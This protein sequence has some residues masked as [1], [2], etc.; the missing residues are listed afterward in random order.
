MHIRVKI[1]ISTLY[2]S[3]DDIENWAAFIIG[4]IGGLTYL[5]VGRIV[6]WLKIDDP[7]DAIPIHFG[8]GFMGAMMPGWFVRSSG[9]F[10]SHG[11]Y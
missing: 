11:A 7:C 10:Y 6:E 8:C 2:R 1:T 5:T 9:I 4:I 3:N